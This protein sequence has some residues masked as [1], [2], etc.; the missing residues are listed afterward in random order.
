MSVYNAK[1]Y[2]AVGNG[3]SHPASGSYGSLAALQAVYGTTVGGVSIALT[4]EL[5]WLGAQK[6]IDT[7]YAAGGG[8]AY[9][10]G[11][12]PYVFSNA[13]SVSDGSG[14]LIVK[15]TSA[16]GQLNG[17]CVDIAGDS[18]QATTLTW[19]SD[20]GSGRAAISCDAPNAT[21][22][23]GTGRFAANHFYEGW[24][25]DFHAIGPGGGS[26]I[27]HGVS[28]ANMDGIVVGARRHSRYVAVSGFHFAWNVNGDYIE[29]ETCYGFGSYYGFYCA[30]ANAT[31]FGDYIFRRCMFNGNAMAAL[32]ISKN[33][34]LNGALMS[35]CYLGNNPYAYLMEA[36]TPDSYGQ[37]DPSTGFIAC[38]FDRCNFEFIN[39]QFILDD[40]A[41]V[42]GGGN[43]GTRTRAVIDSEWDNCNISI[44]GTAY[45]SGGRGAYGYVD[46]HACYGV[47]FMNVVD[48]S[49]LCVSGML[50][51]FMLDFMGVN[52]SGG[53]TFE[54]AIDDILT[55]YQ[56]NVVQFLACPN[57]TFGSI[58]I[59]GNGGH[60]AMELTKPGEWSGNPEYLND[61]NAYPQFAVL[62]RVN[63]NAVELGGTATAGTA[64]IA[65][66]NK[67]AWPVNSSGKMTVI[68]RRAARVSCKVNAAQTNGALVKMGAGGNAVAAT[69]V[70]DGQT[71][72]WVQNNNASSTTSII[73]TTLFNG[74]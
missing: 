1:T 23:G 54:G 29:F 38:K 36:G 59:F 56:T 12:G 55:T 26:S 73:I 42:S 15:P 51:A 63:Y 68:A 7:A 50:S 28:P 22:T 33:G 24:F 4:N 58:G 2:G 3:A 21:H 5:D 53:V 60:R 62:E 64:P 19:P 30:D 49:F 46:A 18:M 17:T 45:T 44:A 34:Q 71:V 57:P 48:G 13:N 9:I 72:G 20:L 11:P 61:N 35:G 16:G 27:T 6:A 67:Q 41:T 74:F 52:L 66:I 47:K 65:G 32:A 70:T 37:P 8:V 10:E 40:N 69:S 31:L 14:T 25:R 43:T 39:N